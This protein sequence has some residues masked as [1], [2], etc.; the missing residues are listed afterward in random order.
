MPKV[1]MPFPE[2]HPHAGKFYEG[3]LAVGMLDKMLELSSALTK[4]PDEKLIVTEQD[5][6]RM[7]VDDA[8][9]NFDSLPDDKKSEHTKRTVDMHMKAAKVALKAGSLKK[10]HASLEAL[11]QTVRKAGGRVG[12]SRER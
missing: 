11:E 1:W 9:T 12:G 10:A 3:Y 2:N 7:E 8:V 4:R 5:T 6:I